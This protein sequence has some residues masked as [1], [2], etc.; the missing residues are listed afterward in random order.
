M[1][2]GD[3]EGWLAERLCLRLGRA[4]LLDLAL[5]WIWLE[6]GLHALEANWRAGLS[7]AIWLAC[8]CLRLGLAVLLDLAFGWALLECAL[9]ALGANLLAELSGRCWLD[10]GCL[11]AWLAVWLGLFDLA[12]LLA[13]YVGCDLARCIS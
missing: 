4:V 8:G 3:L 7:V 11:R 9:H 12:G 6:R 10:L 13:S 1:A 2:N 5:G